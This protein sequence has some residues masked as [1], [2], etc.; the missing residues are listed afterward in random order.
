MADSDFVS[1][2]ATH[3]IAAGGKRF[4]PTLV[5]VC[6]RFG[7]DVD[8]EELIKAALVMELTHVASLYH[9]DVMDDATV[10]RGTPSANVMWGNHVA[11]LVGDWL[12]TRASTTVNELGRDFVDLQAATFTRLVQGQIAETV[13]PREG[14][15]PLEHHLRVIADKTGSLIAASARFGGMVASA[16]GEVLD[17]L[18]AFGE[19]LGAVFQLSDDLIDITSTTTGKTPGIDLREGVPT[20]PTLMLAASDDPADEALKARIAGDLT[21]DEALADTLAELRAHPVM[22]RARAEVR[23]RAESARRHLDILPEGEAKDLL[24]QYCDDLVDR[25]A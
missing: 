12:F 11:I 20:L 16:P 25:T 10:R 13:G 5:F 7:G 14:D 9:D 1:E 24:L 6:S 15:D 17:A 18:S 8:E 19:E 4:R 23:R 22:E 3:I 21:S 2:A